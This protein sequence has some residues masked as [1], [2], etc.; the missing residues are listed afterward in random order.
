MPVKVSDEELGI[1]RAQQWKHEGQ[2]EWMAENFGYDYRQM[3][4]LQ[5]VSV[6]AKHRVPWR[7]S[8]EYEALCDQHR[9]EMEEAAEERRAARAEESGSGGKPGRP[10]GKTAKAAPAAKAATGTGRRRGAKATTAKAA[11][12]GRKGRAAKATKA[13][14][15]PFA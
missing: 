2:L 4:P 8:P 12:A 14:P 11:P 1:E 7:R 15:D 5:L 3:T 9:T 6:F 10:K 13:A